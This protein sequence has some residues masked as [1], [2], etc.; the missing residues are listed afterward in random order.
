MHAHGLKL[1]GPC[2]RQLSSLYHIILMNQLMSR[3]FILLNLNEIM[4]IN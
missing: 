3:Q 2:L 1:G 4:V